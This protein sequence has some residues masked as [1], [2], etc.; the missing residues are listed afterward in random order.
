[1]SVAVKLYQNHSDPN[2]VYKNITLIQ[3]SSC[4]LTEGCTVDAPVLLLDM[5]SG[6]KNFNYMYIEE[7]GR[8]YHCVA[9]IVDGNHLQISGYTDVLMSFWNQ[10][11]NSQCIAQRST[12]HQNPEIEEEMMPFKGQ[13][14]YIY[15]KSSFAFTPSSSGGCYILTVGGK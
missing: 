5:Q 10:F 7:F 3:N 12:S 11:R 2:V 6:I 4:E 9:T 15:R 8:Y 1:M 14:K 13:P